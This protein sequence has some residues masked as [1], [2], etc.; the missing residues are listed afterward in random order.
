MSD[1]Q[2]TL[3][4]CLLALGIHYGQTTTRDALTS[5]LPLEN[6]KLTPSLFSRAAG[7]IGLTTKIHKKPLLSINDALL[8]AVL[9]LNNNQACLLME[10]SSNTHARISYPEL[11][12][13]IVEVSLE[14]LEQSYSG[15]VIFSK[16]R[17]RFDQRSPAN[18]KHKEEDH[19][20]WSS[21]KE[22]F[23]LYR[24]VLIAAFFIN[25][26][27]VALP[28]FTMNV[29]DRVI[30]NAAI[31]TLWVLA[32]GVG[33]VVLSDVFLRSI[34]GY[35]LDLA[36]KR[37]DIS[38]SASIMERVLGLRMEQRPLSAGSFAANLRSFETIR[39]FV[40][41]ATMTALIDLPFV[42][43][44]VGLLFWIANTMVIPVLVGIV[45]ILLFSLT[46]QHKMAELTETT[47]R[48]GAQRNAT[49]IESLVGLDTLKSMAAE[50]IMQKRWE[51]STAFLSRVSIH[52]RLLASSN[53]N[54]V[55]WVQQWVTIAVVIF[56]VY[57]I[58]LGEMS[59]GGLIASS[60]LSARAM[61][62]L[63]A[64]AGLLTQFHHAKTAFES[65]NDIMQ[66]PVERPSNARFVHREKLKGKIEFRNVSFNYPDSE[67][68]ALK[69]ISFTIEPGEH[70]ALLGRIGSG[71]SSLK[72]LIM[73][74]Y[75]PT[76]GEVLVDGIDVRQLDLGELRQ[77]IGH[78]SQDVTLFYG[79]LRENI[80]L[81][82]PM[83]DDNAVIRATEFAHLSEFVN[84]H[85]KGFDM[86]IGERG[87]SLSGGQRKSVAL[88]RAVIHD[89]QILLL[90]EPTGSM[91]HSTETWVNKKLQSYSQG[92]TMLV[93]THRTPIL[94]LV[95]R[96]IVIDNGQIVADGPRENV[97][98]AL[99]EGRIGKAS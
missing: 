96:I 14:E 55:M 28:L 64:V 91:D 75:Q 97:A 18:A 52:L 53:V 68:A 7:R 34:R 71:K 70:V 99:R 30:P 1:L 13:A 83:A 44:F 27:A 77:Q 47:Y 10:L 59:M 69:N 85:P 22:S 43:I 5:G 26:L 21:F 35:Y 23:P 92:K 62:P 73:G 46:T 74:L 60:M 3:L 48:A 56:G 19:W 78:V 88:A 31:E 95:D 50:G 8:P 80:V 89:P 84:T 33:V 81:A 63:G 12:D 66:K 65:L 49:L 86:L 29:Y 32:I 25:L 17:F 87:E 72:K 4:D 98:E 6:Q 51:H 20:F 11:S 67:T 76:E 16:P 42:I 94:K 9:I 61:A 40:A 15:H 93:A 24:D 82:H 45:I 79:S 54:L 57:L 90:D 39:D 36:S 58:T 37:I 2:D 38:L 41:S